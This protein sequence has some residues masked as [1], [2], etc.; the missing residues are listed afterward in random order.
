MYGWVVFFSHIN[1][2]IATK[3]GT[4]VPSKPVMAPAEVTPFQQAETISLATGGDP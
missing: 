3:L 4:K 1:Q 2:G